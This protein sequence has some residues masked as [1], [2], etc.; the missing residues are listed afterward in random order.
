M[1]MLQRDPSDDLENEPKRMRQDD[2]Y[3]PAEEAPYPEEE[4]GVEQ[5]EQDTNIKM[6][7]LDKN[8][9]DLEAIV[10]NEQ[11]VDKTA[12]KARRGRST[13]RGRGRAQ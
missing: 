4:E 9:D 1:G 8:I 11:P 3:D 12:N 6:E 2:E 7:Q 10:K 13:G 5:E